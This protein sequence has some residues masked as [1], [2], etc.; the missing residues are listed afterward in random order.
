MAEKFC[1]KWRLPRHFWVLLHGKARHG[2]DDFTS[3]PK[4]GVLRIFS[5]EKS[6]AFVFEPANSGTKGQHATS[7]P[8]KPRYVFSYT[9]KLMTECKLVSSLRLQQ[10]VCKVCEI[11][12]GGTL[13]KRYLRPDDGLRKIKAETCSRFQQDFINK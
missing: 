5:P 6:E 1:R 8:P 2:T 9:V 11:G 12:V 4:E 10:A 7:G 3:P 13:D